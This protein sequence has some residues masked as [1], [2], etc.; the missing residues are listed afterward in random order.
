MP[1][2]I[3][4]SHRSPQQT[5]PIPGQSKARPEELRP[6]RNMIMRIA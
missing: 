1:L 6:M 5:E 2:G 4:L 3:I